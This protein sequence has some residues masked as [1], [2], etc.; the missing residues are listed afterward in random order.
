MPTHSTGYNFGIVQIKP[1]EL[2]DEIAD[3]KVLPQ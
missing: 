2:A 1:M 3:P